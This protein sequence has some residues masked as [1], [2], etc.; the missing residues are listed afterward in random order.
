MAELS[1]LWDTSGTGDGSVSG[2]TE[3]NV[4]QFL[5]ALTSRTANLGGV[6]PD[7]Q[8]E[9]AVSGVA[10][11]VTV[12]TGAALAY[13]FFY[14]NDASLT[15]AISTPSGATRV[16]RI[17]LR[18]SWAAQTVRITRIAGTEGAGTPAMTQSAGT[19]WDIPLATVS[20]TTL[21]VI[22]VTDAREW[23]SIVGDATISTDKLGADSVT[24]AKIGDD[25]IDSEHYVDGSIDTAH[26]ADLQVT[27]GKI[28]NATIDP[29][30]KLAGTNGI[31]VDS[32]NGDARAADA[33]DLQTVRSASTQVASGTFS[34]VLGGE[35]NT[36]SGSH[37]AAFGRGATASRQGQIAQGIQSVANPGQMQSSQ[38][39]LGRL[40]TDG[41][42]AIMTL[43]SASGGDKLTVPS[44]TT[45]MF[46]ILVVARRTDADN[47]SAAYHFLGAIDN[48]AGTTALVAA[49]TKTVV[50]EDTAAWD[51]NVTAE[52]VGD[53]LDI[54]VTG[55]AAKT[56]RWVAFARIVEVTG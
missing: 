24:N 1:G 53:T 29:S 19:T 8:N 14:Y 7:Y 2:Y 34:A 39:V 56:I 42:P 20:I 28:A 35:N 5:R 37:S 54:T 40:T 38:Y 3:A 46:E 41:T 4:A 51:V 18:V 44:D 17:V 6:C 36:A 13:G 15:V 11:P 32:A 33:V 23:I 16:D 45:W 21:G 26:I 22:T 48:N 27:G 12:A 50:A 49:V 43:N 30:T 25:Q 9:L 52:N 31:I 55:E 47:E 10:T